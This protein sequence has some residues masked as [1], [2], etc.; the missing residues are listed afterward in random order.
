[1]FKQVNG[2]LDQVPAGVRVVL[3]FTDPTWRRISRQQAPAISSYYYFQ[4]EEGTIALTVTGFHDQEMDAAWTKYGQ[5][6][7]IPTPLSDLPLGLRR[8]LRNPSMM[9]LVAE[10]FAKERIPR[11]EVEAAIDL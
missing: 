3:T 7:E 4:P 10:T 11:K 2:H 8:L 6:N 5:R 9:Q 1:L